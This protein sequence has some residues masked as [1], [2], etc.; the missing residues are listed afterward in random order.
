MSLF[1]ENGVSSS[2]QVYDYGLADLIAE[3]RDDGGTLPPLDKLH[4]FAQSTTPVSRLT[5][6]TSSQNSVDCT[7]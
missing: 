6:V 3:I 5:I 2:E 7:S 4:K 1:P